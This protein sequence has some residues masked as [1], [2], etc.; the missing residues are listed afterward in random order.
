LEVKLER[1]NDRS[2]KD[3]VVTFEELGV[4]RLFIDEADLFKNLF[5]VTKMRNV[6]GL[7]QG[8]SQKASDMFMKTRYIDELTGNRGTVMA[9]GTPVSNTIAEMYTMQRYLQYDA[10]V[11]QGLEHFDCWASTFGETVTSLEIAP[12]GN[13]FRHKTRFANFFNLPELMAMYKEVADIQTADMLNLPVPNAHYHVIATKPSEMQK[14]MIAGLCERAEKI[15][16]RAVNANEDNMLLVTNDGRKIALDQRII[17]PILPDFEG[18]KVNTCV[19]NVY[20][21]FDE[22]KEQ[23]LTQLIFCDLSTPKGKDL[24]FGEKIES[25]LGDVAVREFTSVYRDVREKLIAKGVPEEE[26]AFIH[27]ADS[28]A[29]KKELFAKVRAGQIRILMGSTS[30]MGAGTNVQ[31]RLIALHDL[32]CPWRPRDLEQRAGRIVRRGNKNPDVHIYRY[33]TESTFDAY[34]YQTVENKQRF[35]SQI[36]TSKSPA[37]SNEDIDET[38]LSYAEVKALC[39]GNPHIKE[40]IE[41]DVALAKLR[42]IKAEHVNQQYRLEDKVLKQFPQDIQTCE[43]AI[44]GL[45][46]DVEHLSSLPEPPEKEISPMIIMGASFIDKEQAGK[47]I[48]EACKNRKFAD[49]TFPL[50]SYKGFDTAIEYDSFENAFNFILKREKTY[51]ATLSGDIYGNITRINNALNAIPG[52]LEKARGQL[53]NLNS[54]FSIAKAELGKP[55]PREEE[56]K[57]KQARLNELNIELKLENE[58]KTD[59]IGNTPYSELGDEKEIKSLTFD[60][61]FAKK[62]GNAMAEQ[63]IRWSGKLNFGEKAETIIA[64]HVNDNTTV[65]RLIK[66][67]NYTAKM[68]MVM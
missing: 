18:S 21:I 14:E 15:R 59:Y 35:I 2:R 22:T 67:L 61:E 9:T 19:D 52:Q 20:R 17:N 28:E 30:K 36:M 47:A 65:D 57:Q 40:K 12:E 29:Q 11:E 25:A 68:A 8:D 24:C 13:G 53:D 37:R 49:R 5:L 50:G 32:D 48:I 51:R 1:L 44:K 26:I 46:S 16:S 23:R 27:E 64:F 62:L 10:L 45:K 42:S 33:V 4:D 60:N 7:A 43:N 34:L 39:A 41:L 66:Q 38:T 58:E 54:Q 56:M 31:D 55:F 3:D 63:E 6:A